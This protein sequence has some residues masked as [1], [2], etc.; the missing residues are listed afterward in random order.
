MSKEQV[1]SVVN[2]QGPL[3]PLDISKALK[4]N[5]IMSGAYLSELYANKRIRIS[6][7]KIGG[8]PLYY[9]PGQE[10]KLQN[11]THV[12][13][14][15]DKKAYELL[16]EKKVLKDS[17]MEPAVRVA[18]Q[19]L[20]DFAK[21]IEITTDSG[22]SVYWKWYLTKNEELKELITGKKEE[23]EPIPT[24][25]ESKL[26][27]IQK[28]PVKEES[29][30]EDFQRI[31]EKKESVIKK[32]PEP[33]NEEIKPIEKEFIPRVEQ[34]PSEDMSSQA[35][36]DTF[37]GKIE[38]FLKTNNISIISKKV[39]RSSDIEYQVLL[40]SAIGKIYYYVSAKSKK[41]IND[42]D[43]SQIFVNATLAKLPALFIH[44]GD[45]TKKAK[46][47]LKEDFKLITS[48]KI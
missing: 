47:K 17:D 41:K 38:D 28:E 14:G 8:S 15:P 33:K 11:F 30:K 12:L 42:A 31:E 32:K 18:L 27:L 2:R 39:I 48:Y 19:G 26:K 24:K 6:K 1:M 37:E 46:E 16:K 3:L 13:K 21:P 10:I 22:K 23:S 35:S 20:N 29:I 45:M 5:S 40:P 34:K 43:L 4:L 44:V 36:K 25:E 7:L 9:A